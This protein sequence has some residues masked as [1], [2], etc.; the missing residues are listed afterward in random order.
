[1][2]I[3][4]NLIDQEGNIW[5]CQWDILECANNAPVFSGVFGVEWYPS[6]L[7]LIVSPWRREESWP[8]CSAAYRHDEGDLQC[9]VPD[10][11]RDHQQ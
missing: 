6:P 4:I 11:E 3:L 10:S 5:P 8:A 1:M 7:A 9:P 2:K